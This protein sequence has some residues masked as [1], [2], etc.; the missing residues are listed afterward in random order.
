MI[1][2]RAGG[3][4]AAV[5]VDRLRSQGLVDPLDGLDP[6]LGVRGGGLP[7]TAQAEKQ[8]THQAQGP[9]TTEHRQRLARLACLYR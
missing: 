1:S 4:K 2:E 3:G 5:F 7:F 6:A 8:D 9:D